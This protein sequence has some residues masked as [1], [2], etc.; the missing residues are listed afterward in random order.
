MDNHEI[1]RNKDLRIYSLEKRIDELVNEKKDLVSESN[2]LESEVQ[3]LKRVCL[4]LNTEMTAVKMSEWSLNNP[5]ELYEI[6]EG[7]HEKRLLKNEIYRKERLIQSLKKKNQK[8]YNELDEN[9]GYLGMIKDVLDKNTLVMHKIISDDSLNNQNV[10]DKSDSLVIKDNC[11]GFG[12]FDQSPRETD[13]S[14]QNNSI[15][16]TPIDY[17]HKC[18]L[19]YNVVDDSENKFKF[20]NT[21]NMMLE[22]C[23]QFVNGQNELVGYDKHIELYM[24][25]KHEKEYKQ[26]DKL[27]HSL[28]G[29]N[30]SEIVRSLYIE[31]TKTASL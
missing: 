27:I 5:E 29:T 20:L 17:M 26:N 24:C 19:C 31:Y 4:N 8:L 23:F 22:K 21:S 18:V 11:G 16:N 25:H 30:W 10:C 9:K 14:L 1:L 12:M 2:H 3:R 13:N 15:I 7:I 28:Q 6:E